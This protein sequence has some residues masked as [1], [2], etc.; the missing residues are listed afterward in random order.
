MTQNTS[1]IDLDICIEDPQWNSINFDL[2]GLSKCAIQNTLAETRPNLQCCEVSLLLTNDDS[3][4][5]LNREYRSKDKATNVLSFPSHEDINDAIEN[6]IFPE[7]PL[8]LGDL[9]VAYETVKHEAEL[10]KKTLHNHYAH[11]LIHGTLHL[12]G[13]DHIEDHDAEEMESIEVKILNSM[14]IPNP[15]EDREGVS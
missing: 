4:Q 7:Q 3:I 2:E 5:A 15:Y 8:I 13:Y 1:E 6:H 9:I 12:L 10:E 14:G 11:L